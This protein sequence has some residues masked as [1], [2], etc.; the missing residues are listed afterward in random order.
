M[1]GEIHAEKPM[2]DPTPCPHTRRRLVA[3][4]QDA[5]YV[6]CLDCGAILEKEELGDSSGFNE[7]L[8]DA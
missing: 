8:S 4:D 7:S 3:K 6:E 2:T 1:L 5:E